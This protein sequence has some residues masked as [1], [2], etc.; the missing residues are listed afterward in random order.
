MLLTHHHFDHSEVAVEFATRK[1]C[2]VRA[3]DPAYCFN[4]DP[5]VDGELIDV[6][7]LQCG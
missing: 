7:G 2:P 6:D 1:G 3:L 5:L 4:A